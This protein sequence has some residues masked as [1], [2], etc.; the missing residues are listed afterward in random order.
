MSNKSPDIVQKPT[1]PPRQIPCKMPQ[2]RSK[3]DHE[4]LNRGTLSGAGSLQ[5]YD[6]GNSN[7]ATSVKDTK[8]AD[9][10]GKGIKS[11]CSAALYHPK[12]HPQTHREVADGSPETPKQPARLQLSATCKETWPCGIEA[13][14]CLGLR[15]FDVQ[16]SKACRR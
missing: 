16:N 1:L 9:G 3:R 14:A 5:G 15:S 11:Q 13:S 6:K 7:C 12:Y 2:E 4:A 10:L 8:G